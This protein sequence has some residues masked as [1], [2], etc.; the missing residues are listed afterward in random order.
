[1]SFM[2]ER[3]VVFLSL[4][5]LEPPMAFSVISAWSMRLDFC[6][7]PHYLRFC[8]QIR[9]TACFLN[10]A[11]GFISF[12]GPL[13][14]P[15]HVV[16]PCQLSLRFHQSW[17]WSELSVK[18]VTSLP[19][20]CSFPWLQLRPPRAAIKHILKRHYTHTRARMHGYFTLVGHRDDV[21]VYTAQFPP[22]QSD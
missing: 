12:F 9:L 11:I 22:L 20:T 21:T 7:Y 3:I 17:P 15:P 8:R 1:M 10:A 18:A 5:Q 16:R 2:N 13:L 4:R 14:F 6:N 19:I